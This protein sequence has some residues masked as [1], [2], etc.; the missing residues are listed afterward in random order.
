MCVAAV[1]RRRTDR[2]RSERSL[3]AGLRLEDPVEPVERSLVEHRSPRAL[4]VAA[5]PVG[6]CELDVPRGRRNRRRQIARLDREPIG[7]VTGDERGEPR[8]TRPS[9]T[10]RRTSCRSRRLRSGVRQYRRNREPSAAA[11]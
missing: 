6:V 5:G 3:D 2:S 4:A 7:F 1:E 8:P 10:T 9:R 11:R